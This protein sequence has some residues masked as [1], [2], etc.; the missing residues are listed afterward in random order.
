M[1]LAAAQARFLHLTGRKTNVEYEG[2]QVNQARTA[3]ANQS[4]NY[5]N[6]LLMINVPTPPSTTDFTKVVY[7]FE[8]GQTSNQITFMVAKPNGEYM[9]SYKSSW[10]ND[11]ALLTGDANIVVSLGEDDETFKLY[12]EFINGTAGGC[13]TCLV[14]SNPPQSSAQQ[15]EHIAHVINHMLGPGNYTTS[16]GN[17]VTVKSNGTNTM[18]TIYWTVPQP[19]FGGDAQIM[20]QIADKLRGTTTAQKLTDLL[21]DTRT[22]YA[23]GRTDN[24]TMIPLKNRLINIVNTDLK[25]TLNRNFMVGGDN[26]RV[27]GYIGEVNYNAD[28]SIKS[29]IG[30]DKYLK[31]LSVKEL[32]E[33]VAEESRYIQEL[34]KK[35]GSNTWLV[36]YVENTTSGQYEAQYYSRDELCDAYYN[37]YD[38]SE[39]SIKY[40]YV[41]AEKETAEIKGV[42]ARFGKDAS[43]R[44]TSI[45]IH[46]DD[47]ILASTYAL[48]TDITTDQVAYENAMNQY[49]YNKNEYDQTIQ[50]INAKIKL[51]QEKDRSLELKL[52]QLDTEQAA[53]TQE[54][55]AVQK[56]LEKNT[57]NSFN[58]F[59]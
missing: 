34:D 4:A 8:E 1:G 14:D 3:L 15:M 54:F 16:E 35:F 46:A 56:V 27:A 7:T 50:Q 6:Q 44:Y 32:N 21:Y 45:T 43:G 30:D 33:L 57:E 37:E 48:K 42:T 22:A 36:R 23:E 28:G 58:L 38:G 12:D 20:S 10:Q 49:Y 5:Y 52:R 18:D 51:V 29:Y 53:I 55:E 31:T 17:N 19:P 11:F 47:P 9:V 13:Y 40:H 24:N 59:G 26:L 25:A 39:S 2:Q 41:G